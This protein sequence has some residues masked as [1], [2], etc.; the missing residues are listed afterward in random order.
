MPLDPGTPAPPF[1]LPGSD[2]VPHRLAELVD[3][4]PAVLIF[5]RTECPTCQLAFPVYGELNRRYAD[6]VPIVAVGQD[7]IMQAGPWLV[8]RGFEGIVLDDSADRYYVSSV[9][10]VQVVP[11]VVLIG[12]NAEI[13]RVLQGWDRA[14]VNALAA[15]LGQVTGGSAEPVSTSADGLPVFKPG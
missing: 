13:E 7:P 14:E 3:G 12:A 9:Y 8:E 5:F 6:A 4:H 1:T 11:T 10:E 15:T 2:G